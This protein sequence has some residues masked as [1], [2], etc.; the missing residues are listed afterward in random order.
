L[1]IIQTDPNLDHAILEVLQQQLA[2]YPNFFLVASNNNFRINERFPG[3]WRG[4][5]E[6]RDLATSAV[7]TGNQTLLEIAMA[8][9]EHLP[10]L[11]TRLDADDGLHHGFI[12]VV[13]E[14]ALRR[15]SETLATGTRL[16]WLYWCA[17]RSIEWYWE[18]EYAASPSSSAQIFHG[19][20]KAS[21][22]NLCITPGLTVGF[23]VGTTAED[24]PIHAHHLLL[25]NI[26]TRTPVAEACGLP[27][28]ADCLLFVEDFAFEAVRARTPTSAGMLHIG[29]DI[30]HDDETT[31]SAW[32]Q[33]G[34]QDMLHSSFG[35]LR[36]KVNWVN[37]YIS[38]HLVDIAYDNL[39]GQCTTGHSCKV[40]VCMCA[41]H[42]L[43]S[44][45]GIALSWRMD[46]EE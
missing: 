11:E 1:W 41:V 13:Q 4:G 17:R 27:V 23:P 39:M 35:I 46:T 38:D 25:V 15:F 3:A 31:R 40:S 14:Q 32:L 8:L 6:T 5:A 29:S 28:A 33:K 12:E 22:P 16:K 2:P 43:D 44:F 19:I 7:Y 42:L 21:Q 20:L 36:Q 26:Q 37:Q 9:S 18:D 30:N 34:L 10:V 24:V 45:V